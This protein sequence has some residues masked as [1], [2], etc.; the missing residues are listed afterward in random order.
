MMK[1]HI[2]QS[3]H[4]DADDLDCTPFD[5]QG[6]EAVCGSFSEPK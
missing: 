5:A 3:V 1:E 4:L 6:D 2:A